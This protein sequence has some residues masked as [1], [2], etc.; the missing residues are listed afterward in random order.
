M[1]AKAS[2]DADDNLSTSSP[3]TQHFPGTW[4]DFVSAR[5]QRQCL[6]ISDDESGTWPAFVTSARTLI[7]SKQYCLIAA[8]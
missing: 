5:A 3:P 8:S 1:Q 7:A 2:D 4:R 6:P